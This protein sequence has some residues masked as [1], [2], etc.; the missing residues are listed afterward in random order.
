MAPA[1]RYFRQTKV[2]LS[3]RTFNGI[4]RRSYWPFQLVANLLQRGESL[5]FN[6]WPLFFSVSLILG[7]SEITKLY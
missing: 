1:I 4:T 2:N 7:S 6:A 3:H 5:L